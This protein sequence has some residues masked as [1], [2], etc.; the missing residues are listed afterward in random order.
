MFRYAFTISRKQRRWRVSCALLISGLLHLFALLAYER[1]A[2]EN[3]KKSYTPS[4]SK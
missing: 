4:D 1:W 2:A 3:V